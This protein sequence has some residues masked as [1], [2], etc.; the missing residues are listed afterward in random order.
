MQPD[1][2]WHP[3]TT[4]A[5]DALADHARLLLGPGAVSS[6]RLCP[7]CGSSAHGRPWLRHDD[8]PLHVSLARSGPHLVTV[9]SDR[10]V[11]VDVET[12]EIGVDPAL[13]LA[14]GETGDVARTW[15]C[16]EAVLKLHGTGLAT[17]MSDVVLASETWCDLAAPEGYVAAVAT[18]ERPGAPGPVV[19]LS[20]P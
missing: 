14:P 7:A 12:A 20:R 4:S 9:I 19:P 1:V 16:K 6:G 13:V 3:S 8:S 11:G 18:G 15:V 10:P 2:R 17:A 5:A